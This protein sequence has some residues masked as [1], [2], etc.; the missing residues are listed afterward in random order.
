MASETTA[1]LALPYIA[2]AQAQKHVTHNEALRALDAQ[3][4]LRLESLTALVPPASPA[5]GARWFVPEGATGTFAGHAGTIAAYEDGAWDF[6]PCVAGTLALVGDTRRLLLYDGSAWVSPLASTARGGMLEAHVIEEDVFLFGSAVSTSM[7]IPARAVVI[8]VSTRTLETATGVSAYQC[9]IAGEPAAFGSSLGTGEGSTNSGVIGPRA[10]YA[11]TPV[12]LTPQDGSFRG[13]QVRVAIHYMTCV[14][15]SASGAG[16]TPRRAETVALIARMPHTPPPSRQY[17]MDQLVGALV[18]AGVWARLDALYVLAAA[19]AASARVNW[20]SS[21]YGLTEVNSPN[22]APDR[23]YASDG[24]SSYLATGLVPS[25][26][27]HFQQDTAS[28][29]AVVVE[30]GHLGLVMGALT[31]PAFRGSHI[32]RYDA[33]GGSY[34]A[35]TVTQDGIT[36]VENYSAFLDTGFYAAV[37][38]DATSVG[39]Y[40]NGALVERFNAVAAPPTN[41]EFYLLG[42][43]LSGPLINSTSR[44]SAAFIGGGLTAAQLAAFHAALRAY[45]GAL[46]V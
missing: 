10:F 21:S 8:G 13:G 27:T 1:N 6:L 3:V 46:G 45:L 24:G 9:G 14:T 37:R 18:D 28:L 34:C 26:A 35:L 43:N 7:V 2:A 19:D 36:P 4:H 40:R 41:L 31:L 16:Y 38:T 33:S 42:I 22:F 39:H 11:D 15:P 12:F 25:N 20:V 44:L 5:E 17:L 30:N 23:G 32:A 29:G